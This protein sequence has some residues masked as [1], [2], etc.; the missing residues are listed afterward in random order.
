M[1][2]RVCVGFATILSICPAEPDAVT[3]S[4]S[5]TEQALELLPLSLSHGVSSQLLGGVA[6]ELSPSSRCMAGLFSSE[7]RCFPIALRGSEMAD[8]LPLTLA[9]LV[10]KCFLVCKLY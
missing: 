1:S 2:D 5:G 6:Q 10:H 8:A 9:I 4:S 7:G 3:I